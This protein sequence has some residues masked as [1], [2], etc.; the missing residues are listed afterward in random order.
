MNKGNILLICW[1]ENAILV[2]NFVETF[3][4][5][6]MEES[7][8]IMFM[9]PIRMNGLQPAASLLKDCDSDRIHVTQI[10]GINYQW[11]PWMSL[12]H[13]LMEDNIVHT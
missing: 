8:V 5:S 9:F 2:L 11:V 12:L 7:F 6:G 13:S 3:L 1:S 10:Q 4:L